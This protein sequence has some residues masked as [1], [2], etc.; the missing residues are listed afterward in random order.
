M[1]NFSFRSKYKTK[2]NKE[3][4]P[5]SQQVVPASQQ[6]ILNEER[7]V[8]AAIAPMR[9][10]SSL[11]SGN[12]PGV[13]FFTFIRLHSRMFIKIYVFNF[14]ETK[15]Q[16]KKENKTKKANETKEKETYLRKID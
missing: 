8:S 4:V 7:H 15:K 5:A 11:V 6:V 3:L 16:A 1:Q 2:R 14:K 10:K 13:N 12:R 9:P